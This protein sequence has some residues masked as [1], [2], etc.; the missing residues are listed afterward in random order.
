MSPDTSSSEI[1][2]EIAA[3]QAW[4]HR[5]EAW[6]E[7]YVYEV[8]ATHVYVTRNTSRRRQAIA[9]ATLLRNYRRV[10]TL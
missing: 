5:R 6:R 3:G 1:V 7:V 4:R 8:D 9:R 10:V 2:D